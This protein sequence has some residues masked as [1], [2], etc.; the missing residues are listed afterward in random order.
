MSSYDFSKGRLSKRAVESKNMNNRLSDFEEGKYVHFDKKNL[1]TFGNGD[2]QCE[3]KSH[4]KFKNNNLHLG[5]LK[6]LLSEMQA[7]IYYLDTTVTKTVVYVGA[8]PGYHI[9][10][11]SKLFPT[12]E[13]HLYDHRSDWDERLYK[14]KK[15]HV[16]NNYFEAD[17][18]KRWQMFQGEIF[19][20]SDIRDLSVGDEKQKNKDL[21]AFEAKVGADMFLQQEWVEKIK[22][23][24][25]LLKFKLPYPG[26]ERKKQNYLDGSVYR[27]IFPRPA[28]TETRLLVTA[29]AYRDWDLEK[30]E[31]ICAYHNQ[32]IRPRALYYNL[33]NNSKDHIYSERG[34][35]N[36]YESTAFTQIIIDYLK[37]INMSYNETNVKKII[38][39]IM[40]KCNGDKKL[41][42]RAER[43]F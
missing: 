9:Y 16:N 41:N 3:Y 30:Y 26:E 17:D 33:L 4:T 18:V 13:F 7:I 40:D 6:L 24:V 32:V 37:K 27:Q 12:L 21:E 5:Q 36:D 31:K 2:G 19:F 15:I 8:G 39:F 43:K 28:S 35:Y 1:F 14:E 34:L 22:P 10:V 38:D 11:L 23:K 20:I 25:S 29:L 42:L